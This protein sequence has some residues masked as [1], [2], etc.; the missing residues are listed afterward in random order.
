MLSLGKS[1]LML[2]ARMAAKV[3]GSSVRADDPVY[4]SLLTYSV[5]AHKHHA[6][7]G[8]PPFG[9]DKRHGKYLLF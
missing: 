8:V 3:E 2:L 9:T 4:E 5:H 1:W 6:S 7:S